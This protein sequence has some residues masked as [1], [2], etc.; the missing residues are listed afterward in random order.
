MDRGALCSR[1]VLIGAVAFF[2]LPLLVG[3]ADLYVTGY[4]DGETWVFE[5]APISISCN[6]ALFGTVL[7]TIG[8]TTSAGHYTM[9]LMELGANP[10]ELVYDCKVSDILSGCCGEVQIIVA[11]PMIYPVT[12]GCGKYNMCGYPY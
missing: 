2:L 7:E 6:G 9:D 5:D 11:T 12:L 4:Y 8:A 1:S 10:F 3:C